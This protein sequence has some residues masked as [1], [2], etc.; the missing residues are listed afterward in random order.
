MQD[1]PK[2]EAVDYVDLT[3]DLVSAYVSNNPVRP[4]DLGELI[5]TVHQALKGLSEPA[6]P[7]VEQVQKPTPAQIKKSITPDGLISFVDGKS[8]QTLKRH[9]TANGLDLPTYREHYG[10]PKDYPSVAANYAARR[11]ELAKSIGLGQLRSRAPE[12]AASEGEPTE[13]PKRRGR[14]RKVA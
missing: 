1:L 12:A 9:L 11:S 10:L 14:P 5:T 6:E 3:A 8:Y 7:A 4:A 2:T 13:E